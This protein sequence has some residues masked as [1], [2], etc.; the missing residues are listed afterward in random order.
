MNR[1]YNN[2]MDALRFSPETKARMAAN[3]AAAQ[4]QT[5]PR[6]APEV[7][8]VRGGKR[9][10]RFAAVAAAAAVLV[11]GV[12]GGAYATGALMGVGNV[13]DDLF[14]GPPAQTEVVDK[15]GRPL[16]A[17][18]TSGGVTITA[19]AIVGDKANYAIVFSVA[20]DDGTPFEGVEELE[21]GVLLLG[22][23]DAASVHVDG[24][25]SAGGSSHFYD[26]DPADNAIQYVEQMSV[27][28]LGDSIIGRTA[29]VHFKDLC[30]YVGGS[31]RQVIAEGTWDMKFTVDYEDTSVALPAG[32]SFEMN[33]MEATLDSASLSPLALTL[34][35]TVHEPVNWEKQENGRLSE[36]NS[37][38]QDR[39][40][41]FPIAIN[42]KDGTTI[43]ASNSGGGWNADESATACHKNCMFDEFLNLDEVASVTI[44][45]IEIPLP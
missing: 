2:T 21:T 11:V 34:K 12:G 3:L 10:W 18:A 28:S 29:R 44:G 6:T 4:E 25:T 26:A 9:R 16:G 17:S 43:D 38:Q 36:H 8:A 14:G 1:D 13:F 31:E 20:K 42:L 19:E 22:F 24:V 37:A 45:D 15:I 35:Y 7:R 32:Q 30:R 33:G 40:L 39:F 5:D 41:E 27:T 23:A